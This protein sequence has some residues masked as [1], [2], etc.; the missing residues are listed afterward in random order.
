VCRS[1]APTAGIRSRWEAGYADT[2][3]ALERKAWEDDCDPLEGVIL[4]EPMA[5]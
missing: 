4:H 2:M 5:E 1:C 3:R